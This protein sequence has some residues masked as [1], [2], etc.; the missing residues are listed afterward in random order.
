MTAEEFDTFATNLMEMYRGFEEILK[1]SKNAMRT[2]MDEVINEPYTLA[3]QG[4]Q[5]WMRTHTPHQQPTI[6]EIGST[7]R[8]L[9]LRQNKQ[10]QDHGDSTAYHQ[11]KTNHAP[12]HIATD[13]DKAWVLFHLRWTQEALKRIERNSSPRRKPEPYPW[14]VLVG[15]Y[16]QFAAS[17][18]EFKSECDNAVQA[19][20]R[21]HSGILV[22]VED[23]RH[24]DDHD[25]VPF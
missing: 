17:W 6:A 13:A 18:P 14:G 11:A 23:D 24:G 4:L 19:I 22:S 5:H 7:V 21:S 16:A 8:A 25:D 2:L 20:F 3:M 12:W 9:R 15:A 10:M 1:R